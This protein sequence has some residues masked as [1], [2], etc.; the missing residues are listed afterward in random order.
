MSHATLLKNR[1]KPPF[2]IEQLGG[3]AF[4][5]EQFMDTARQRLWELP[6]DEA[7]EWG[8]A[9][10][11]QLK[12]WLFHAL[13]SGRLTQVYDDAGNRVQIHSAKG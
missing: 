2:G 10:Y 6:E 1:M 5:A 13:E 8:A 9:E 4:S 11:D 7:P 3:T 12:A